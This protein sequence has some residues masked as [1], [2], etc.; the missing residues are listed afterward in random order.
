MNSNK[1][2]CFV[3]LIISVYAKGQTADIDV[4]DSFSAKFVT[5]IRA[6]AKE[7]AYLVT[8][9]SFYKAGEY[10]WF[11]A[12]LL[13][14]ASLKLSTQSKFLFVDV[15]NNKDS[16]IKRVIL[17]AAN[18]QTSSRIRFSDS[19]ATGYYWLRAY[20]RQMAETD[21]NDI[22]VK[23][24]F[25]LGKSDGYNLIKPKNNTV[26]PNDTPTITFYPEG[27]NVITGINSVVTFQISLNH[28]PLN[29]DGY[30]KDNADTTIV[31]RFNSN[32]NGLGKFEFEPSGY[33]HYKAVINWKGKEL[34]YP[35]PSFNFYS[36]QLS[37]SKEAD[38]Y[39]LRIL[40]GDSIYTKNAL[41]YVVGISKDSMVFASVGKGQ[42]ETTV[43]EHKLPEGIASF[44]LF[45]KNFKLLSERSI[46][47]HADNVHVN[48]ATDK[49][50]YN[51]HDKVSLNVS[52]TDPAQ[53]TIPSLVAVSVSD[54]VFSY[55]QQQCNFSNAAF[56]S[57]AIDNLF[58]TSN[59]CFTDGDIDLIMLTKND[60]YQTL[61][62]STDQ[63]A[64]ADNDS[65][66]YIKGVVLNARKEPLTNKVI[67]IVSKS[68]NPVFYTDTTDNNGRFC[69]PFD[70]YLDSTEF[71]IEVKN[72]KGKDQ[73]NS[74]LLDSIDYPKL[75][76]PAAFKQYP[77]IEPAQTRQRFNTYYRINENEQQLPPVTVTAERAVDYD[78]SKRV[79]P[80]SPILTSK[81][82]DGKMPVDDAILKISGLQILNGYLVIHGLTA[83]KAPGPQSEPLV[84]VEKAPVAL[85]SDEGMGTS[86]PVLS[87][88]HS[89]NPKDIDFIE[90]LKN[91]DA[92]AYGVRGA[93]G[94]ILINLLSQRRDEVTLD[95]NNMQTFYGKGV[96]QPV[97][98]PD[99]SYEKKNKKTAMMDDNRS[100]LFWNGNYLTNDANN[101]AFSFYT[102]DIPSTYNIAVTGI[103]AH[104]D[105]INKTITVQSK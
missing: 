61:T 76:T 47:V 67:T 73:N 59:N 48:I 79:S 62:K 17:D 81:D 56:N 30:V 2:L 93:N 57:S 69:F 9:K 78:I 27:G 49:N 29:I 37:V 45:D 105:I 20:T 32:T 10:M 99:V 41:T 19:L 36:G 6:N 65:L 97:P 80:Y 50:I 66:L 15:V 103:T 75:T 70:S 34:S 7:R 83:L 21:K 90:V 1:L 95:K 52:I 74:I 13:N 38:W 25:V 24:L 68:D 46:Y 44:Y 72:L 96:S 86:S 87:Y 42:Y 23:P 54:S 102:S 39:K 82:L 101:S 3:L 43:N 35:L 94:V 84:L 26:N 88:L 12:F 89:L 5:A 58:L 51:K 4:L 11:K 71:V 40:L 85:S 63:P 55:Q 33:K 31:T 98:F 91:G 53:H 28:V 60:T 14:S 8:D 18:K 64:A 100:T 77:A 92:A 22:C 104:G 16:V